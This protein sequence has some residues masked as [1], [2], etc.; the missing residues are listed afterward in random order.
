[1]R[2]AAPELGLLAGARRILVSRLRFLGDLVL[3]TP[4]LRA[5][6][7]LVPEARLSFLAEDRYGELLRGHPDLDELWLVPRQAAGPVEA[8]RAQR[9]LVGRLRAARFEVVL[10]LFANP[11][12][13]LLA[14]ATGAGVRVGGAH[15][16]RGH[17][18]THHP[19]HEP[20]AASAVD[21]H[22]AHLRALGVEHPPRHTPRLPLREEEEARA[23]R[24]LRAQAGDLAAPLVGLHPGATWRGKRWPAERFGEVA[25]RL[26]GNWGARV[27]V[28][29]GPGEEERAAVV[30]RAGGARTSVLPV[31]G[32]R[33]LAAVLSLLDLYLA[34]DCGPMHVAAATGTP[35]V[36]I[37]GPSDPAIWFP[38]PRG[39][40]HR[41]VDMPLPCRPCSAE[42]C[43]DRDCL[44]VLQVAEVMSALEEARGARGAWG[45]KAERRLRLSAVH[46]K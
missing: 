44:G 13:A 33:E 14:R 31:L 18:F 15:G 26:A 17:L 10:D 24:W 37:F 11:R 22:L 23:A 46:G 3:V 41:A 39:E 7:E 19:R 32:W 36:G 42:H 2:E 25:A 5:L 38:Y 8:L 4:L 1:M 9:A 29:H 35:T 27:V 43:G 6:R 30:A 21:Y 34:N 28:T 12:S 45:E 20:G 40:G 16:L